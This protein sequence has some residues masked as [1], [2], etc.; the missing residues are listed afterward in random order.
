MA[1]TKAQIKV[2]ILDDY[3]NVAFTSTDKW[4]TTTV[5]STSSNLPLLSLLSFDSYPETLHDEDA[6]A[7]RLY[8]Y[9]IIC[10]MRERTKFTASLLDRLPNLKLIATTGPSNRGID[11]AHAKSKGILVSGTG[12]TGS[13]SD[14]RNSTLE[15]IWALILS[16]AR[17]IVEEDR[18]VK[19]CSPQWQHV[20]PTGLAGK[21]LGLIGLGRLGTKIAR[22]FEMTILAWSPNLT[23]SRVASVAG[24]TYSSSKEH[25]IKSS[26]F[27]SIH[28][29]LSPSTKG[30]ITASDLALLKPTAYFINTSRGPIVD[31]DALVEVLQKGKIA[32]AALDVYDVEPLPLDH[33]L[34]KCGDRVTLSPHNAY[35]NDDSYKQHRH[36]PPQ[37]THPRKMAPR[38]RSRLLERREIED[39]VKSGGLT[40]GQG[41][42]ALPPEVLS[43]I[44]SHFNC[45]PVPYLKLPMCIPLG[46]LE[47][48]QYLN[49]LA[50]TCQRLRNILLPVRWQKIE[51]GEQLLRRG[52]KTYPRRLAR[53]LIRQLEV[54]T[55]RNPSL[56][57][58]VR[59]PPVSRKLPGLVSIDISVNVLLRETRPANLVSVLEPLKRLQSIKFTTQDHSWVRKTE[60]HPIKEKASMVLKQCRKSPTFDQ[61]EI[62]LV[63]YNGTLKYPGFPGYE[64][65]VKVV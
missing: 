53:E 41:L 16:A 40:N 49:N 17:H 14:G 6:L 13:A 4:T 46:F 24:V 30:L 19:S 56:A 44:V 12:G 5:S 64:E 35:V 42:P 52:D 31:E 51:V 32:G 61:I 18:N 47:R 22:L 58:H 43:S 45:I 48:S 57:I 20:I 2:A 3:Q 15:H 39:L 34:R 36:I 28:M 54:V 38:T 23:P 21:T 50:Q 29:V 26:D 62:K 9:E 25:L 1:A 8:P 37:S 55:V 10:S 65:A 11:S 7:E 59:D 63:F 33:P 60:Y 27:V